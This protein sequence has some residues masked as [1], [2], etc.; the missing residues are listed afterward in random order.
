LLLKLSSA[1]L[2]SANCILP[3]Q[4]VRTPLKEANIQIPF[5][6]CRSF[7]SFSTSACSTGWVRWIDRP[8]RARYAAIARA[9]PKHMIWV[10]PRLWGTPWLRSRC[11]IIGQAGIAMRIFGV[12]EFAARLPSA[13]GPCLPF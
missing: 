1:M 7:L 2:D 4:S 11:F 3:P 8:G 13:L 9:M 5:G 12:S 10:T 6:A